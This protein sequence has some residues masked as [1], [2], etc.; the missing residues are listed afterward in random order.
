MTFKDDAIKTESSPEVL[1]IGSEALRA[2]MRFMIGSSE[3][4]DHMKKVIFYGKPASSD[5]IAAGLITS[6][7]GANDLI[8]SVSGHVL[9]NTGFDGTKVNKRLL[10][11][12]I[13]VFTEAGE[14][15]EALLAQGMG[16]SLDMV[17]VA[18]ELGDLD[19]YEAIA[20]D[21][22]GI[23]EERIRATV[24][25][26]LKKRYPGKFDYKAAEERDLAGERAVLEAGLK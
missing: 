10:H 12:A 18:E 19:W 26:K 25:A 8:D 5:H 3:V 2:L 16:E 23:S 6:E 22:C 13:G 21:E 17:N 11:A 24:I 15:V 14:L 7:D 1:N 20:Q 4:A 9:E